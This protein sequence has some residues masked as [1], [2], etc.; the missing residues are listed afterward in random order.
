MAH[1]SALIWREPKNETVNPAG[2]AMGRYSICTI[3]LIP[4]NCRQRPPI[5]RC[6][7]RRLSQRPPLFP[8]AETRRNQRS[9]RLEL[10]T[11]AETIGSRSRIR[12]ELR[13][14]KPIQACFSLSGLPTPSLRKKV[15]MGH[16][17][18]KPDSVILA[19][20]LQPYS[21][22][23]TCWWSAGSGRSLRH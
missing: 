18:V 23:F 8:R 3:A 7:A 15:I 5:N 1:H 4:P 11:W 21:F 20:P 13:P 17:L 9:F 2:V 19:W 14:A 10:P 16:Q 22:S 12:S 6:V